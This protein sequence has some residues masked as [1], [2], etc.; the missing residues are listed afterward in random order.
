MNLQ[1]LAGISILPFNAECERHGDLPQRNNWFE[2]V[3]EANDSQY[4]DSAVVDLG[5]CKSAKDL[6][7]LLYDAIADHKAQNVLR[8]NR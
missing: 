8:R 4:V 5:N 3:L 1:N 7:A 2:L 6:F